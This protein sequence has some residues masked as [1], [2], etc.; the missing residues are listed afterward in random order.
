MCSPDSAAKRALQ[1]LAWPSK[2]VIE[3]VAVNSQIACREHAWKDPPSVSPAVEVPHIGRLFC[4]GCTPG[5]IGGVRV[6]EYATPLPLGMGDSA[7][8]PGPL[9]LCRGSL[10][11][12]L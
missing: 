11:A 4:K 5:D 2:H 1:C 10:S 12:P 9:S 7:C 6:G 8:R 3:N